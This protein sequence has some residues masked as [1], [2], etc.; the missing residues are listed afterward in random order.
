MEKKPI[1]T[2]GTIDKQCRVQIIETSPRSIVN[3]VRAEGLLRLLV[4]KCKF[5]DKDEDGKETISYN[6]F[7]ITDADIQDIEDKVL[8]ILTDLVSGFE[9]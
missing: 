4:D 7:N 8:P 3:V 5:V 9:A 2:F 6:R 1:F